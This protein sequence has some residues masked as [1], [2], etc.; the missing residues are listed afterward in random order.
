MTDFKISHDDDIIK[1]DEGLVF[2]SYNLLTHE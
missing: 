2:K 1:T